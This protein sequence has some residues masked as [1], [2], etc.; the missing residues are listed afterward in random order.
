MPKDSTHLMIHARYIRY[1]E[2]RK[3][4]L[5][6]SRVDT[7]LKTFVVRDDIPNV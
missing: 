1:D 4:V 3:V 6:Q 7:S 2:L 5:L